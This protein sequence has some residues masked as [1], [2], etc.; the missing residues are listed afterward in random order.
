MNQVMLA[1]VAD[2]GAGA[3]EHTA[4]KAKVMQFFGPA[5]DQGMRM[6]KVGGKAATEH[7]DIGPGPTEPEGEDDD[8]HDDGFGD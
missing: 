6:I 5:V 2:G 3:K 8:E 1:V 4:W 7:G